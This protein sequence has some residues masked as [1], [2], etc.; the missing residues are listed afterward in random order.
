MTNM[1]SIHTDLK[2][3]TSVMQIQALQL[4]PS[5][6]IYSQ[7][8]N[9]ILLYKYHIKIIFPVFTI[10]SCYSYM[11]LGKMIFYLLFFELFSTK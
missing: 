1:S 6:Y 10:Y 9:V 5:I 3:H 4:N 2:D 7:G 8:E 11:C